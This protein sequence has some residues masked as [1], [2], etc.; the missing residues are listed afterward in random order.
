L[1]VK[2]VDGPRVSMLTFERG[3]GSDGEDRD[4]EEES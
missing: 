4:A 3:E 1:R 2:S